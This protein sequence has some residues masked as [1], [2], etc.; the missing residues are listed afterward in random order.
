MSKRLEI[1]KASLAKKEALFN[2]KLQEHFDTV[3]LANGQPLNDKRNGHKTLAKWEKQNQA[4]LKLQDEIQKTKDAIEFEEGRIMDVEK[5]N[6]EIIPREILQLVESGVLT[7]WRKYPNRFFVVGVDKA[8][9]I[10][11]NKAKQVLR[12]YC[13]Q[14]PNDEQRKKFS[15]V[16]NSLWHIFNNE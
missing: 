1:L 13:R 15:E 7:Q 16:Y 14:I 8:R 4:L 3:K 6:A 11:D 5:A 2:Q 9:I 10:W 12:S